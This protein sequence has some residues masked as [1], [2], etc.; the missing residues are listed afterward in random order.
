MADFS[1]KADEV[2]GRAKQAAGDL[3]GNDEL[4]AEG[5][6]D[7]ARAQLKQGVDAAVDKVEDV[8]K[9]VGDGVEKASEQISEVADKA[10]AQAS[11]LADKASAQ[12]SE[13][14]DRAS[15]TVQNLDRDDKRVVVIAAVAGITLTLLVR[16]IRRRR[17]DRV[18]VSRR[19]AKKAAK[20]AAKTGLARA[21]TS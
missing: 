4:R 17:T 15:E 14:A 19:A 20:R 1:D 5:T 6:K 3:T 7:K 12:A 18:T 9:E 13:F 11:E 10:S 8:K 21:L 2:V 16:R